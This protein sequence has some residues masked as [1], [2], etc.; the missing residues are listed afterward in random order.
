MPRKNNSL[1]MLTVEAWPALTVG[2]CYLGRIKSVRAEKIRAS[3]YLHVVL[4]NLDPGHLGQAHSARYGL[5]LHPGDRACGLLGACG[6]D[7]TAAGPTVDLD[8]I[9]G[10][11]VGMKF[12]GLD[13]Q[14]A[15]AFDFQGVEP[16]P[17][18]RETGTN[19]SG[20]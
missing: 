7:A 11:V 8:R 19:G 12:R 14:G 15:E 9:V 4:E 17:A 18:A 6:I 2:K 5:P 1:T 20:S 3:H 16:P 13:A 10:I